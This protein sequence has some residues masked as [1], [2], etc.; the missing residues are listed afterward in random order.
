LEFLFKMSESVEIHPSAVVEEGVVLGEGVVIGPLSY[1]EAGVS[2]G[3]GTKLG[4]HVTVLRHSKIGEKCSLHSGAVVGD[5]PQDLAFGGDE[6][7]VEVGD[8]CQIRECVTIHRGTTPG[9]TTRVGDDC[10]LMACS[11]LAHNVQLGNSVI[12][13]NG[14]L[15]AGHAQVGD[16]VF[17]GGNAMVHQFARVGRLAMISGATAAKKDVPPFCMTRAHTAG[18]MGLNTVGLRRASVGSRDRL[19]LKR[20]LKLLYRSGLNVSQALE[21]IDQE[22]EGD[23]VAELADFVRSSER[24]ICSWAASEAGA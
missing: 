8:R 24:G 22:A 14:V 15:L 17:M 23:L 11:H 16:H 9:S 7:Y 21:R 18:L 20:A 6:S 3:A 13:A 1:V 19:A 4:P 10:M 5:L 12:L 2:I